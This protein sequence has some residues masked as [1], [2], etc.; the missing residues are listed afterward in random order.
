MVAFQENKTLLFGLVALAAILCFFSLWYYMRA[1]ET[2]PSPGG[3]AS[4]EKKWDLDFGSKCEGA[5]ALSDDGVIIAACQD[6]FVY[7]V[8]TAGKLQWKTFIGATVASPTIGPDGAIY[9]AD[10][11]GAVSALNRSGLQRWHAEVYEGNTYGHNGGALGS[12]ML[13][14]PSRNGLKAIRLSNG[15]VE[16][17][18][19]TGTDQWASVTLLKDGT[20]VYSGRGRLNGVDSYGNILWQYPVLTSEAVQRNGGL[21]PP[22]SF[23]VASGI[24]VGADR[25]MYAGMGGTSLVAMGLGG[26]LKWEFKS[27]GQLNQASP[28]I[29]ADGTIYYSHA[30]GK[31]YAFDLAGTMMW[32]IYLEGYMPATPVLAADGTIFAFGFSYLYAIS[33]A[34]KILA[35]RDVETGASASPTLGPDGTIYVMNNLGKLAAYVGG[36]GGLMDSPWPKFQA[37]L[38]NTGNARE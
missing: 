17:S 34:G 7:A 24:A 36:H 32:E 4:F 12:T 16:W 29:A 20:I 9:I 21:P 19:T 11:N 31:L 27:R 1:K 23:S 25:Q 15:A 28:V 35:R 10:N 38:A 5:L 8:D 18:T 37:D 6:G 14:S 3:L 2:A 26:D 33:P 30:D 22:G 13:Y